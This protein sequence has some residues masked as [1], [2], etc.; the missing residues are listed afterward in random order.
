M[1][2][3]K[4][5]V[6]M[7]IFMIPYYL[8]ATSISFSFKNT[9]IMDVVKA[10]S[11]LTGKSFLVSDDLRGKITVIGGKKMSVRDA[12]RA[13]LTILKMKGY[14]VIRSGKLYK[15]TKVRNIKGE[16]L[17]VYVGSD[18]VPGSDQFYV[19][20]L[21]L[22]F[23]S[24]TE[25]QNVVKNFMSTN[26]QL[27]AYSPANVLILKD[28]GRAINNVIKV[29]SL[30]DTKNGE[31]NMEILP[32]KFTPADDM[33]KI[34]NQ[35]YSVKSSSKSR[36][37]RF[38]KKN[39]V[40]IVESNFKVI[41][42]N[43]TNSVIVLGNKTDIDKIKDLI[44]KFDVEVGA[45]S[46]QIHVLFLR[47]ADATE[48]AATISQLATGIT[49]RKGKNKKN[50]AKFSGGIKITADKS[51][52]SLI[53]MAPPADYA[54]IK[55]LIAQLDVP[56][57]QVF[58]EAAI[59][60]VSLDKLKDAG[61]SIH[62]GKLLSDGESIVLGG[63]ALGGLNTL[64]M[65]PTSFGSL[66]GIFLGVMGK[67]I[68]IGGGLSIPGAAGLIRAIQT[69]NAL[70]IL[71]TPHLLTSD[72][73]EAEIIVGENVPFISGQNVTSGGNVMTSV[74]RKDIGITLRITPQ[75]NE[76][77]QIRLK[78]YQEISQVSQQ[79]PQ[80]LN[81]NQQGLVTRKRSAKTTVV[82]KDRQTVVIGGLI[83]NEEN[84]SDSKVPILGDIPIL[85]WLFKSRKRTNSKKDLLIIITPVIIK[86]HKDIDILRTFHNDTLQDF[87]EK[88]GVDGIG[89]DFEVKN[90]FNIPITETS[91]KSG[92]VIISPIVEKDKTNNVAAT[93]P[94]ENTYPS[95][96]TGVK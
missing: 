70:N 63:D 74:E 50:I 23:V 88:N 55:S 89:K 77:D 76:S 62:G 42:E 72:N 96:V 20:I 57:R 33:V 25:I 43:R 26:G 85:G 17:T 27:V 90:V 4:F 35:I 15:I 14:T 51:T 29:L 38:N 61:I 80:G 69:S 64:G 32:L 91:D 87:I 66:A 12:Y 92:D 67:S 68:D 3:I 52:N 16:P 60:E 82:V 49:A 19:K 40:S 28:T 78:I 36:N 10:V 9:D 53:I 45:S 86:D 47:N 2:K 21:P 65:S 13:F 11:S 31:V 75:I 22:G 71:S 6:F 73:E 83:S 48:L 18:Y 93:Y 30:L 58:V 79:Q 54:L 41:S 95:E 46:G 59:L 94:T 81:V 39:A 56:R 24:A 44:N 8:N 7:L 1:K 37:T 5:Y 84:I 34:I